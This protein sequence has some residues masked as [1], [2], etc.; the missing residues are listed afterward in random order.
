MHICPLAALP[1]VL[2]P[3]MPSQTE[4]LYCYCQRPSHGDM[5]ACDNDECPT[6]WFHYE[7]V[8]LSGAPQGEWFCPDCEKVMKAKRKS[9]GAAAGGSGAQMYR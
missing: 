6:E 2:P 1:I 9:M 3:A 8:G 4:P 5:V 7:C